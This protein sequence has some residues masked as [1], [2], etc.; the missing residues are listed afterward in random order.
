VILGGIDSNYQL[1]NKITFLN[2]S[3]D[4]LLEAQRQSLHK[5]RVSSTAMPKITFGLVHKVF[6]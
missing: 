5:K 3:S 4:I 2:F 1:T 6:E